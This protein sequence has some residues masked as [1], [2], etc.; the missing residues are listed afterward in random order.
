MLLAAA[1]LFCIYVLSNSGRLHIVDEASLFSVTESLALRGQVDTNAIAWTQW[2]NSPGE[3]LGAFGPDGEVYS[4]KGPAPAFLAVPWYLLLRVL[5]LLDVQVGMLQG[6]L[7]WNGFVTAATAVLLWLTGVRLGYRDRT[8][9]LLALLFGLA[10][11]AWPYA[12][13]F[14]GEPLS[15]FALLLCFSGILHWQRSGR[16]QW[17]LA[18]GVGAA[19]AVAT[20]TAHAVLVAIL[21][22]Y[23]GVAFWLRRRDGLGKL[24]IAAG[25]LL[26]PLLVA[27]AL[28]LAYNAARFGSPWNTGYHFDTGEGFTTP[29]WEGFWGLILSPYRSVFLHT[30]LFLAC[31]AAF[32]PFA[33]RHRLE[34]AVIGA[35]S[36]ALVGL[37]SMW[38]MWWGG[39]AWGPRF[40]VPLTPLW[41]LALAPVLEGMLARRALGP[42]AAA[43]PTATR[44]L[45]WLLIGTALLSLGVQLLAVGFNFVN[46]ETMLRSE[47][48]PTDWENPLA[49]GPPAQSLG[50]LLLSPVFGQLRLVLRGG[51]AA[52]SDV[53]WLWPGGQIA[54]TI[55]WV[56]LAALAT[57]IWLLLRWWRS[58]AALAPGAAPADERALNPLPSPPLPSPPLIVLTALIPLILTGAWLG[59]MGRDPLYGAPGVGYQAVLAELCADDRPGDALIN[60]TAFGYHIPM[61]WLAPL[62]G[63]AMPVYG[64][65][66][67]SMEHAETQQVL[68]RALAE[69]ERILFVTA[70][71]APNAA[72]NTI[73]RWLA[74]NAYKADDR[75][76]DDH[77]LARYATALALQDVPL[78]AHNLLL[79]DSDGA[80]SVNL[81]AS[82]APASAEA[83]AVIPIEIEYELPA[84]AAADLRWFVQLLAPDGVAVAQLDSGP[85]DNYT[86]FTA[87]PVRESI[88]ERAGLQLPP[89]LAPGDYQLIAGV[90]NPAAEGAP[91]LRASDGREFLVLSTLT[92]TE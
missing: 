56:G 34:A 92:V 83:G 79:T 67:S 50:D 58:E 4:K 45:E 73:E 30:P 38:W 39:Y 62:C 35:L 51:L 5:T 90:Y 69:N 32:V 36:L 26:A 65:A 19:L 68:A 44:V 23:A 54:W 75:W 46:Y 47:F 74:D 87:L 14:F 42:A 81:L 20:V 48:F 77:R 21:M 12:R 88:L 7:L 80:N 78:V 86:P 17:M 3:V 11:I 53:A 16:P 84:L 40:L 18:A 59:S 2:V 60:T 29:I 89:E 1:L 24:A 33:R 72:E 76:F 13:L 31:L 10:T 22:V 27:G 37:Y 8:G 49:Y 52:N 63:R 41:V 61:N 9:L 70:G 6:T 28:L 91:R 15:A 85:D 71:V 25:A 43:P 64:Y 57:L 55:L 66:L 82:R